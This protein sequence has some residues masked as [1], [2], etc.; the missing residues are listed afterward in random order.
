MILLDLDDAL[1]FGRNNEMQPACGKMGVVHGFHYVHGDSM[2]LP[3]SSGKRLCQDCM[4]E[5]NLERAPPHGTR[6]G[7]GWW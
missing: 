3:E 7:G 6:H 5:L 2:S 4:D 1:H